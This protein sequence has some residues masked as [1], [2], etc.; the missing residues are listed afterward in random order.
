MI[1]I[2]LICIKFEKVGKRRDIEERLKVF[3]VF[4]YLYNEYFQNCIKI[5]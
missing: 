2:L 1:A 5:Y 4:N 3:S